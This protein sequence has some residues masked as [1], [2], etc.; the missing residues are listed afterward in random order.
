MGSILSLD[1]LELEQVCAA[2]ASLRPDQRSVFLK[3]LAAATVHC[4][5]CSEGALDRAIALAQRIITTAH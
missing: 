3:R 5:R 2:A 1:D 4:D